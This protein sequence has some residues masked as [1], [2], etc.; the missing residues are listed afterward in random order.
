MKISQILTIVFAIVIIGCNE[1]W[2]KSAATP[3]LP[4][5]S[6]RQLTGWKLDIELDR[7][8]KWQ[9]NPETTTGI[10]KMSALVNA[11]APE[12]LEDFRSLGAQLN[13]EKELLL[14]Q[15]TMKGSAHNNLHIYLQP[16]MGRIG[17]LQEVE[18]TKRGALLTRQI[19]EHLAAYHNYFS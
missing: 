8:L 1:S 11:A 13:T 18:N 19:K 10:E 16:L 7:G 5:T 17:E 9:A 2:K 3:N 12:S 14:K 4:K 15:C 6:K